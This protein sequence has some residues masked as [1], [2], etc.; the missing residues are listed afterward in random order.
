MGMF[1]FLVRK[2]KPSVAGMRAPIALLGN[3]LQVAS[4]QLANKVPIWDLNNPYLLKTLGYIFGY[5]DAAYQ[6]TGPLSYD[7]KF[8]EELFDSEIANYLNGISGSETFIELRT[9]SRQYRG[10]FIAGMQSNPV[11]CSGMMLGSS[12]LIGLLEN[13][14][15]TPVSLFLFLLDKQ[16]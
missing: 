16:E 14:E 6:M 7:E 8:I 9:L 1:S 15:K 11:F 2:P 3:I 4:S 10:S 12:E 13:K 5:I